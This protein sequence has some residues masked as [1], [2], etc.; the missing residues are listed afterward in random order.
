MKQKEEFRT[1][2]TPDCLRALRGFMYCWN[3]N[4]KRDLTEIY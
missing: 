2:C 1:D 4:I 3:H